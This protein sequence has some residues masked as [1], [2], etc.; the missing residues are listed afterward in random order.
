MF[1]ANSTSLYCNPISLD[2][3]RLVYITVVIALQGEALVGQFDR[4]E[5][6]N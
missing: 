5:K 3:E 1:G 6:P 4:I 2:T